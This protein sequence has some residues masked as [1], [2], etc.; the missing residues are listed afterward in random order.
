MEE[1]EHWNCSLLKHFLTTNDTKQTGD[2][3]RSWIV[4]ITLK[5]PVCEIQRHQTVRKKTADGVNFNPEAAVL[6]FSR[7][8][9]HCALCPLDVSHAG[10]LNHLQ[11]TLFSSTVSNLPPQTHEN[12]DEV[13]WTAPAR[14][15]TTES[16]MFGGCH[17]PCVCV[18]EWMNE[19]YFC[20]MSK[21]DQ[22]L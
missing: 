4:Q 1:E 13:G 5:S 16:A 18:N 7:R 22:S 17:H 14:T 19:F 20:V 6:K 15:F 11:A 9:L 12:D 21:Q 3:G 2:I 10:P 8:L